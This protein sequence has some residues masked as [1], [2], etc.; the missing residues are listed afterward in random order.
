MINLIVDLEWNVNIR[1]ISLLFYV[2]CSIQF[3][4]VYV[5]ARGTA[6][7]SFFSIVGERS[8]SW[9]SGTGWKE[10]VE[11]ET[12]LKIFFFK[13]RIGEN[14][15]ASPTRLLFVCTPGV[16]SHWWWKSKASCNWGRRRKQY[17]NAAIHR[18]SW[19]LVEQHNKQTGSAKEA[20]SEVYGNLP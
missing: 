15:A 9:L 6:A 3:M 16:M 12:N 17:R 18:K 2:R 19:H 13:S 20:D 5:W 8:L 7:K 14:A 4:Y 1:C 11:I 10:N